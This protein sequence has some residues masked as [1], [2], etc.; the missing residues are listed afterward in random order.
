MP[1]LPEVETVVR[2]LQGPMVGRAFTGFSARW[3]RAVRPSVAALARGLSGRR[4]E[5][6]TRRGKYLLFRLDRGALLIH[7]KMSGSLQVVPAVERRG[8][9]VHTV[10]ELDNGCELRFEDPR[11]FGRVYLADDPAEVVGRLGPEPLAETFTV[12][13][14]RGLFRGRW[15]RLK[16]L[17]LN[18]EF[19]AG[20]GNI[21]ADESCFGAG[22][23]PRRRV[24]TLS[25]GE[26]A[27]L[28]RSI[29]RA[30]RRGIMLRGASIDAVYRGG[31][32]QDHFR[33]YGR[34]GRPCT[35]CGTP[36]R[37]VVLGGRSTHFCPSCQR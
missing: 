9:H 24:E 14:F 13:G 15:G 30:L 33:V 31:R 19:I 18:Q 37:R 20:I 6:L 27:R 2:G 16:P 12:A 10:F 17:L 4:V 35:A 26:L 36:V 25:D 8:K 29:R 23:D 11:K 34:T 22:L 32:F 1:E 28:Y 3:S 7:L 5:A 21:Y